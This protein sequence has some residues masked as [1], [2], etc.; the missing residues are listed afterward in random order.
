MILGLDV[1][2]IFSDF[3]QGYAPLITKET[4]IEFPKLHLVDEWPDLWDWDREALQKA[5]YSQEISKDIM[6]RVWSEIKS[7]PL[8]WFS[9]PP[10]KGTVEFLEKLNELEDDVY[11][12]TNR[13][14]ATARDQTVSWLEWFGYEKPTV[15]VS[16][17]KGMCCNA[18]KITHYLDDKLENCEDVRD[19]V[20][21]TK[22]FMLARPYNRA[23]WGVP[24]LPDLEVFWGVLNGSD[25]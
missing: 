21:A 3:Q 12:I 1:D 16:G 24:R 17:E 15:L 4:G 20:P 7:D 23:I 19:N 5:G 22:C 9:L 2:G 6:G 10:H 14:G 11:F 25:V 8:F 18:L 13:L